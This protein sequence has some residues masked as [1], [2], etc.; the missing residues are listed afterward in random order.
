MKFAK[1]M[2][3]V[4]ILATAASTAHAVDSQAKSKLTHAAHIGSGVLPD[5]E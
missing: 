5:G 2:S 3:L 1:K 4:L